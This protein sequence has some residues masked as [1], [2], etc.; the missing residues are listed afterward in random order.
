[1]TAV[2]MGLKAEMGWVCGRND[3]GLTGFQKL[4]SPEQLLF[5]QDK[6]E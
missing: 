3:Q 4:V 6:K 2:G 1:M 5:F